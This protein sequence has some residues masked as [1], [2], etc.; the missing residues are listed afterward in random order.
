MTAGLRQADTFLRVTTPFGAD[1]LVLDALEASEGLSEL[2]SIRLWLRSADAALDPDR[3]IGASVS[4]TLQ[5]PDGPKRHFNGIACRFSHT[6]TDHDLACY[7]A[8]LVPRL[9]LLTLGRDRAVW[10]NKSVPA[11]V[12]AVL[13]EFGVSFSDK[14]TGSYEALDYCV[15]YDESAFE[16]LSRLMENAGIFYFFT[17]A[18]G[19]HTLVL[20]DSPQA[21]ADCADAARV[22]Y[23]PE[24]GSRHMI[25]TIASFELEERLVSGRQVLDD[26]DPLKPSTALRADASP[27]QGKGKGEVYDWPGGQASVAAG[28][29]LAKLRVQARQASRRV[30]RGDSYVYPFTAGSRFTLS[31]HARAELNT[32]HVLRRVQHSARDDLYRN[33]FEAFAADLPF[34]PPLQQARPRVAG[35][36][37]ATVVGPRGEEIWTDEHGRIKLRFHWDRQG[38]AD[39]SASCWVRVMQPAAGAG[40]GALFL[41]RVGQE[42]VV[43]HVDGDPDRPLVTGSVYNGENRPPVKLPANQTQTVLRTRSSRQGQAG[44]EIRL[45]DRK[46]AEEFYLHAQKDMKVEIEDALSLTL[47]R[48]AETRTIEKG[49]RT[50]EVRTGKEV[51]KVKGTRSLEVT[52]DEQ[53]RNDGAY[54]HTIK[55]DYT[56]SVSGNLVLD[57]KGDITIKSARS[58]TVKSGTDTTVKAGANLVHKAGANMNLKAGVNLACEAAAQ[59]TGK[60]AM[61]ASK[62]SA[63]H[64]VEAGAVLV[65]KGALVKAN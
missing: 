2:F 43:T 55:G 21:H 37:T 12:K 18:S 4:V 48:G 41:P 58:V 26:F 30:L 40:F 47:R 9:W 31:G 11:I 56:L 63:M 10:Q 7:S 57:V 35:S 29:A 13:G 28:K 60:A 6:G 36:Q 49:D 15:Q 14:L 16:F 45:E 5:I 53:H 27:A 22:R 64:T 54:Q 39:D 1:A 52:G 32:R 20:A 61:I 38:K 62:A 42:V 33:S 51:H 50:I 24:T 3:I 46:D 59:M 34:R 65:L 25:D 23:F 8:E 17:F 19:S 44:N